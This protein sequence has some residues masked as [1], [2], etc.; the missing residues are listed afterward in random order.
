MV[1]YLLEQ[2]DIDKY[3]FMQGSVKVSSDAKL[4]DLDNKKIKAQ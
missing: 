3:Y 2:H 4:E 1:T